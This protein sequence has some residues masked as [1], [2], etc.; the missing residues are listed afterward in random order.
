[1][2]PEGE[3][4]FGRPKSRW[5]DKKMIHRKW[6]MGVWTGSLWLRKEKGGGHM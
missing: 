1:V 5:E 2:K 3:R 4:P 6:D